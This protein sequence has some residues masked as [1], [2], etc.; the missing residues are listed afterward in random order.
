MHHAKI[1]ILMGVYNGAQY[2]EEA[3]ESLRVQDYTDWSLL[4]RDDGSSDNTLEILERWQARL[5]SR[6]EILPNPGKTNLGMNGNYSCLLAAST[7]PYIMLI[8]HDDTYF[9]NKLSVAMQTMQAHQ[10]KVGPD[11]PVLV[12]TDLTL[13]DE[14]GRLIA[15]SHWQHTGWHPP[16]SRPFARLLVNSMIAGGACIYNRPLIALLGDEPLCEDVWMGYVAAAFGDL[17]PLPV[18]TVNF[19]WHSTNQSELISIGGL[20]RK[21]FTAPWTAAPILHGRLA[22][23]RPRAANFLAQYRDRLSR[24]Q[25]ATLEDFLRLPEMGPLARRRAILRHGLL[26]TSWVRTLGL[27]LLV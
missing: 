15:P 21:V 8:S 23:L 1:Q 5:D 4:V 11:R 3:L 25:I 18:Q 17:V 14:S 10:A 27:L 22:S 2:L 6:L 20:I 16:R 24:K 12:F 19:R 9:P 26:Y 7:A 13:I